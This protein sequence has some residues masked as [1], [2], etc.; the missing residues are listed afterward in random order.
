MSEK[1][2]F[3]KDSVEWRRWLWKNHDKASE[4]WILTYKRHTGRPCLSYEDALEEAICY[5][6]IDSRL[7][8]IDD[9][10]HMWRFAP[11]KTN[12]LWSMSNRRR[13]EKLIKEGR[14]ASTGMATVEAA[15]KNGKWYEAYA[16]SAPPKIPD[17][18]KDGLMRDE[19]AWKN[20]QALAKSHRHTYIHWVM[21]AKRKETREKRIQEVVRMARENIKGI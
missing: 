13:A 20:F 15:K 12:S 9:E 18:L 2:V 7:K 17:D 8:R 6:W 14:M 10:R 11:R 21:T 5:G 16:P 4:I 19:R 3:F 1:R